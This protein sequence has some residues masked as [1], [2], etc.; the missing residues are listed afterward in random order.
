MRGGYRF[1]E[2]LCLNHGLGSFSL[3]APVW[4]SLVSGWCLGPEAWRLSWPEESKRKPDCPMGLGCQLRI[5][6]VSEGF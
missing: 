1:P 6:P 3:G 4:V 2:G 5:L